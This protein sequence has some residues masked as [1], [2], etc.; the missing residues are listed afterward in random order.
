M[1]IQLNVMRKCSHFSHLKKNKTVV[2]PY[3]GI[4]SL[5]KKEGGSSPCGSAIASLTS[6]HEDTGLIPGPTQR[7]KDLALLWL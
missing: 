2:L 3:G 7:V 5:F 6:I 1:P 4:L